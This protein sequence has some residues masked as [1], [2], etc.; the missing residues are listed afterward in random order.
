MLKSVKNA[1]FVMLALASLVGFTGTRHVAH[2]Q[3]FIV[4]SPNNAP[5][6][7]VP[8]TATGV[9]PQT[10]GLYDMKYRQCRSSSD[11]VSYNPGCHAPVAINRTAQP[12]FNA[13]HYSMT[14][15]QDCAFYNN[16]TTG[17]PDCV[18]GVCSMVPVRAVIDQPDNPTFCSTDSECTVATDSCGKKIAVNQR[19]AGINAVKASQT[20]SEPVDNRKVSQLVCQHNN[21]T[22]VLD[23][24]STG[25]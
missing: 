10:S 5:R 12:A 3:N 7:D 13:Y 6:P 19:H 8:N 24:Y 21:C 4:V 18:G 11:C 23:N 25:Q 20:C 17:M 1:A 22:V 9:I 15:I 2:A 16:A 14:R